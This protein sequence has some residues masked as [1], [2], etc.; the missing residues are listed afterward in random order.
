MPVGLPGSGIFSMNSDAYFRPAASTTSE[1]NTAQA[2]KPLAGPE[3]GFVWMSTKGGSG[4]G[5]IAR[6]SPA[7]QT[8]PLICGSRKST[9]NT[10]NASRN[11][12]FFHSGDRSVIDSSPD[13]MNGRLP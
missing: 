13:P 11:F 7:P 2:L 12:Q 6:G 4:G 1:V 10:T 9:S 8:R 5:V 3:P